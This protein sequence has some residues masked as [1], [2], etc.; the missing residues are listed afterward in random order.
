MRLT[1][2]GPRGRGPLEVSEWAEFPVN[3]GA[4]CRKGWTSTGLRGHRERLTSPLLRSSVTGELEPVPWEQA[5]DFIGARLVAL[6]AAERADSIGVFGGGG[7]T[8]EKAC[9]LGQVAR[10]A[11]GTGHDRKRPR[12]NSSH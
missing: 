9:Q 8:H 1:G 7:L 6:S 5:L 3:A 12:L 11:V 10:V 2:T 4:L